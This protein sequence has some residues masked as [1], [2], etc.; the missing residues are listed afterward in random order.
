MWYY[1]YLIMCMEITF[2]GV[3]RTI[4]NFL[5]PLLHSRSHILNL[6]YD[7]HENNLTKTTSSSL[8]RKEVTLM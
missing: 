6:T 5:Y 4:Y 7:A 2:S 8:R 3:V 1:N